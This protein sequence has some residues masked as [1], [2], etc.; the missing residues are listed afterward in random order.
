VTLRFVKSFQRTQ[1]KRLIA[2]LILG[3]CHHAQQHK[4]I[5]KREVQEKHEQTTVKYTLSSFVT[6]DQ[7]LQDR[8]PQV[9]RGQEAN[10]EPFRSA[11]GFAQDA[12]N[13]QRVTH[14]ECALLSS[15]QG[16][17]VTT[18]WKQEDFSQVSGEG[19]FLV[20]TERILFVAQNDETKDVAVD[21]AC[22]QLHAVSDDS[23]YIQIQDPQSDESEPMEFTVTPTAQDSSCCQELFDALSKLVSLHPIPLEEE[24]DDYCGLDDE[25]IFAPP[26][27]NS[28]S[29][30]ERA[31]M[32]ERLDA[33][34]VVP[35]EYEREGDDM[36]EEVG[37]FDDADEDDDEDD[38]M[39]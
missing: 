23:V 31:T 17:Q 33:I 30:D 18:I 39:L 6:M 12:F 10:L 35:P 15:A 8:A 13:E 27:E 2:Q 29:Q 34:L 11:S 36:V 1:K 24:D 28:T 4:S 20:T 26:V 21:A 14:D 7:S 19:L 9:W 38:A 5:R 32:L 25:A 22:I 37:Q 3:C 16:L